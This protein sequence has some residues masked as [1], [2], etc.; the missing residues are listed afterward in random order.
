MGRTSVAQLVVENDWD[1]SIGEVGKGKNPL[2]AKARTTMESDERR[3][4][5][6][7]EI[8]ED[9]VVCFESLS[10]VVKRNSPFLNG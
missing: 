2:E 7:C 10:L 4:L 6:V 5:G 3:K 8:P 9:S 1:S